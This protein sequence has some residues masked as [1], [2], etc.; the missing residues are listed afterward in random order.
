MMDQTTVLTG[1]LR[2]ESEAIDAVA[3]AHLFSNKQSLRNSLFSSLYEEREMN[4][5]RDPAQNSP[6]DYATV[7]FQNNQ[8]DEINQQSV[9]NGPKDLPTLSLTQK[10]SNHTAH[11]IVLNANLE[12]NL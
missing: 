6:P 2:Q 8:I 12:V 5:T 10:H 11:T 9:I 7:G 4:N 3:A 1:V